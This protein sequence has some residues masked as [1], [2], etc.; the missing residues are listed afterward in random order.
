[1]PRRL[2]DR[3]CASCGKAM[4][5]GKGCLPQGEGVCLDCRRGGPVA[6]QCGTPGGRDRHR[7]RGEK[8]CESCRKVWNELTRERVRRMR[9]SGYVRPSRPR[10]RRANCAV[11]GDRMTG[12]VAADV[13]M[14]NDCRPERYWA[15]A[16]QISRRDRMA[17]YERDGWRCQLCQ[18]PVDPSLEPQHRLAATLD[19]IAPRSLTL[20]PDDS[21]QNLRLAH[22]S[23]NSARGN[24]V[25]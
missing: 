2:G 7:R 12:N 25:A 17:I 16:I 13:P 3:S 18:E 20:F 22:R 6:L 15:N 4:W 21:P 5:S 10:P 1:M 9:E 19:H 8:P 24:R 14:H 23:C 11:C